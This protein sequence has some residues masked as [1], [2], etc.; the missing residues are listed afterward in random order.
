MPEA[1][2]SAEFGLENDNKQAYV[3]T[4]HLVRTAQGEYSFTVTSNEIPEVGLWRAELT[5][6]G[7]PADPS[8]DPQRGQLCD[9]IDST[10]ITNTVCKDGGKPAEVAPVPFLTLPSDCAAGPE[11]ATL[12]ADSWEQPGSVSEGR[13]AGYAEST[14][15][16][17]ARRAATCCSSTPALVLG[18]NRRRRWRTNPWG[19][20]WICMFP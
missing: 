10:Q 15:R 4:A 2:Q 7:V 3:L 11:T 16:C 20:V 17:R 5:F 9:F 8:H 19:W 12:R 18:W 14:T 13:Y 1:G 6:W